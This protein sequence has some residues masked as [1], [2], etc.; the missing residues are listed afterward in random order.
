[1]ASLL[2]TLHLPSCCLVYLEDR[3]FLPSSPEELLS[4]KDF[5]SV[6]SGIFTSHSQPN[7]CS[8]LC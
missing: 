1:M 3:Y 6:T 8:F 2:L 5:P 7:K 4:F